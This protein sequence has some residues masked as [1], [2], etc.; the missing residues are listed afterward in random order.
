MKQDKYTRQTVPNQLTILRLRKGL[1]QT[2]LAEYAGI[3]QATISRLER[4]QPMPHPSVAKKLADYFGREVD[5]IW[6]FTGNGF[7]ERQA[8]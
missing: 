7:K 3:N 1:S 2:Q 8:A 4:H 6:D 5:E